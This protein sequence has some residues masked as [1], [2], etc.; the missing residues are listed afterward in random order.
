MALHTVAGTFRGHI[1]HKIQRWLFC[2]KIN[3]VLTSLKRDLYLIYFETLIIPYISKDIKMREQKGDR[4]QNLPNR[5]IYIGSFLLLPDTVQ[6]ISK[7]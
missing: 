1:I 5:N 3:N 2:T 6:G 4:E 7:V